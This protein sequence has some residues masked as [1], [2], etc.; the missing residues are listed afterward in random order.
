MAH[1]VGAG[2]S[3]R[4]GPVGED[5]DE[6]SE[7][8]DGGLKA[9][10]LIARLHQ[11]AADPASLRHQLGKFPTDN[12]DVN[13]LL[14]AAQHLG[15]KAKRQRPQPDRLPTTPLPALALMKDGRAL[16]LAQCDEQR[17]LI[18]DAEATP[19]RPTIQ[20]IGS[21][22]EEWS[23]EVL[24]IAS[25]ASLAGELSRFD[26]SWFIPS[27]VKHRRLLAEVLAISFFLQLFALV[28]PFFFQVVMDKVLVHKGVSTLDVLVIGLVMVVVFES[29]LTLLRS[30]VFSHTT[31]RIDVELGSRLFRHLV[32]LPLGY[33]Q[34]RRVG[35]SV[36]RVR[37]LE[38]IRSFLT[39]NAL[40]LVMDLLFSVVFIAVMLIYSVPLTLVVLVSLP[41]YVGLIAAA[42]PLLRARL[43]EKFRRSAEN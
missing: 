20:P 5:R 22:L 30:Y 25:R 11:V 21:F 3:T 13:D 2:W 10:C 14:L 31:S 27:I 42:V 39:G 16:I 43:D 28:S 40:T 23:G 19:S 8:R 34:A 37:E 9:L 24:L 38:S 6:A 12:C 35:Q 1:E 17:V 15:L 18:Q 29:V 7:R 4:V 36:A 32:Q 41:V 33:F 26:F